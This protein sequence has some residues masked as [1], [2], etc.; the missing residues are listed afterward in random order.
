MKCNTCEFEGPEAVFPKDRAQKNGIYPYCTACLR[1][2]RDR[3][4]V[5][6]RADVE[7]HYGNACAE[8]GGTLRLSL[9]PQTDCD[10]L[11]QYRRLQR[12][13]Y[14]EGYRLLCLQK[15]CR[16]GQ[17]EVEGCTA[18]AKTRPSPY[19]AKHYMRLWRHGA[20]ERP[21]GTVRRDGYREVTVDGR[22]IMEH[23]WVMTE[24]LGRALRPSETVH[25]KNGNRLD[26]RVENLELWAS[27]HPRGQ[28][29]AD[30]VEWARAILEDYA[31]EAEDGRCG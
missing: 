28:R 26:N 22:K 31:T 6:V 1:A 15:L 13:G 10:W 14:P 27:R 3:Q 23:R 11:R 30:L 25:H 5:V 18:V 20:L 7:Q 4:R 2:R 24:Q 16:N 12:E 9:F 21:E 17:C 29:V 19:C 8:C